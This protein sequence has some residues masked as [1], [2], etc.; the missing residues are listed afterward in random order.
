MIKVKAPAEGL[1][2]AVPAA[3]AV[4]EVT[5]QLEKCRNMH[6]KM[7]HILTSSFATR[8]RP[9]PKV[10]RPREREEKKN[11][12]CCD[13]KR[14]QPQPCRAAV[15]QGGPGPFLQMV[16]PYFRVLV[17]SRRQFICFVI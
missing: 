9:S 13:T 3:S 12:C 10:K 5:G 15:H 17:S 8:S 16:L 11:T 4:C 1:P 6:G 2:G 14:R 7:C